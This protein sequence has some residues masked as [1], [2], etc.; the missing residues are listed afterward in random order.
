M[1]IRPRSRRRRR[2]VLFG[3]LAADRDEHFDEANVNVARPAVAKL[4]AVTAA[5]AL[6]AGQAIPKC[7]DHVTVLPL[8]C[9][10][11][12]RSTL[13]EMFGL[14]LADE[15]QIR[16]H[17]STSDIRWMVLPKRPTGTEHLTEEQL[18]QL[19]TKDSLIGAGMALSPSEAG[20]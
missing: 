20:L 16:V 19:V 1:A 10:A 8:A 6:Q 2:V 5:A 18:A 15:M 11:F 13:R 9:G 4:A 14:A 12:S 7:G 17:D 3:H